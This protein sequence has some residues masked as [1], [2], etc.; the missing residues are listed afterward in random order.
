MLEYVVWPNAEPL[1]ATP[2][3]FELNIAEVL[4]LKQGA[5]AEHRSQ[6]GLVVTDDPNGF[7]LPANL[8]ARASVPYEIFF[9]VL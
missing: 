5:I 7:V 4:P 9:E 8:L 2:A 1:G 3:G 6:H